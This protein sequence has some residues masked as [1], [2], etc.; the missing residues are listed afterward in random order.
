M[1]YYKIVAKFNFVTLSRT[2]M[3]MTHAK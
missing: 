2:Y 3:R 1:L